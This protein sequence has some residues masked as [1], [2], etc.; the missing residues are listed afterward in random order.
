MVHKTDVMQRPAWTA[1][2]KSTLSSQKVKI[3]LIGLV[4]SRNGSNLGLRWGVAAGN[5]RW[6]QHLVSGRWHQDL[7]GFVQIGVDSS[8]DGD[9]YNNDI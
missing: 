7:R 9:D 4:L 6:S 8:S 5:S 3:T 2:W 1:N